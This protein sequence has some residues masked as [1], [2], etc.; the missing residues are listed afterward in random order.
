MIN[1]IF[2]ES[3]MYHQERVQFL[4]LRGEGKSTSEIARSLGLPY[5]TI[6]WWEKHHQNGEFSLAPRQG[7]SRSMVSKRDLRCI[8]IEAKKDGLQSAQAICK[9]D[10][11]RL[12]PKN[13]LNWLA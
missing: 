6:S 3:K 1:K 5:M 13:M 10:A 2:A 8:S 11:A 12:P 9:D 4:N 7:P